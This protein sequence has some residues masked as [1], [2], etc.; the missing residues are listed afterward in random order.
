MAENFRSGNK[1][2]IILLLAL[3]NLIFLGTE[4]VFVNLAAAQVN[5]EKAVLSQNYV[6]GISVAGFLL[7]PLVDR[8]IPAGFHRAGSIVFLLIC[9]GSFLVVLRSQSYPVM[10]TAGCILFV[11][12]GL[13]G[14]K[15]Y[16]VTAKALGNTHGF[17]QIAGIAYTLGIVLQFINNNLIRNNYIQAAVLIGAILVSEFLMAKMQPGITYNIQTEDGNAMGNGYL[18]NEIK[19]KVHAGQNKAGSIVGAHMKNPVQ[20]AVFL[21]IS[22]ALMTCI[23][24][25]LDNEVTLVHAAG[26]VNI[27]SW[28]RLLLMCS[29]LCAG[30]LFDWKNNQVREMIMYCVLL[31]STICILLIQSGGPFLIGLIIFYLTAGFFAVYFAVSFLELSFY[32]KEQRL[33]AGLGR[34]VN[35]FSAVCT[36]AVSLSL[37]KSGNSL[38]IYS[39]TIVLFV[40]VG[41]SLYLYAVNSNIIYAGYA[42]ENLEKEGSGDNPD[43]MRH[44]AEAFGL[45]ER[46]TEVMEALLTS[47]EGIQELAEKIYI[48]RAMLYRHI[49]SLNEKTGT[50]NRIGLIQFYYTWNEKCNI[51][52]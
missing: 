13:L 11:M 32:M 21:I 30:F 33:F 31:L 3:F 6:L 7:F 27:G 34:A 4:Y 38:L 43:K 1:I 28:P 26:E 20:A 12:L 36:G 25:T 42:T 15:V 47:D 24:S 45:T 35:N 41:I 19:E 8:L 9:M 51:L 49:A 18:A 46:E 10:L 44:F 50:Q 40:F 23:F 2:R 17:G 48:S 37:V 5:A 14:S 22:V 52:Q 29:G 16:Y 39:V